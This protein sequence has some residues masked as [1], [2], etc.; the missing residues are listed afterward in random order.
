M[1]HYVY[2][3]VISDTTTHDDHRYR[4]INIRSKSDNILIG[5]CNIRQLALLKQE[6]RWFREKYIK[7]KSVD[8]ALNLQ[9]PQAIN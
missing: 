1:T 4:D 8:A 2:P 3:F 5:I 9:V 7:V 6:L